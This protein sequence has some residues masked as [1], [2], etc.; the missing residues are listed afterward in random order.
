MEDEI[1]STL[2]IEKIDSKRDSVRYILSGGAPKNENEDKIY[3]I[4]RGLDF[5]ADISN[6]ITEENLYK[7]YMLSIGEFLDYNN[8]ILPN[9]KYRHDAV[10]VVGNEISHTGLNYKL[11]PK[12]VSKLIEFINTDYNI[13]YVIKSI[14]SHYYFAYLHLF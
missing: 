2:S 1:I 11:L 6:K 3:G 9:Y 5:I 8:M 14:I 12:Y 7:L 10:Y 13:D 4:K